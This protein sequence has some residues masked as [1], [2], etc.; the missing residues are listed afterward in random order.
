MGDYCLHD[1]G[2]GNIMVN[3]GSNPLTDASSYKKDVVQ[4]IGTGTLTEVTGQ[5]WSFHLALQFL[6]YTYACLILLECLKFCQL[7]KL[8]L[9]Q[10][11]ST[12]QVYCWPELVKVILSQWLWI[13]YTRDRLETHFKWN[14]YNERIM[15]LT[16]ATLKACMHAHTYAFQITY[17]T[18]NTRLESCEYW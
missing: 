7:G 8:F 4:C 16:S 15:L 2:H 6:L 5:F 1:W 13:P 11:P 18:A 17:T 14:I 9:Y 3:M 10:C 12:V